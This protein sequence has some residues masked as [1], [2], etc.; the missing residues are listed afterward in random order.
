MNIISAENY[1]MRKDLSLKILTVICALGFF[2]FGFLMKVM[3]DMSGDMIAAEADIVAS[4]FPV[5]LSGKNSIF[6][7]PQFYNIITICCGIFAGTYIVGEFDK[8][9]IRNALT[10]GTSK[11]SYYFAKLYTQVIFCLFLTLV[12]VLAFGA[13]LTLFVGWN[14]PF[15][16]NY[17]LSLLAFTGMMFLQFFSYTALFQMIAFLIRNVGGVI[18]ICVAWVTLESLIVQL[19][20]MTNISFL[21]KIAE[22]LPYSALASLTRFAGNNTLLTADFAKF[23]IPAVIIIIVAIPIGLINFIK[24]D[25]K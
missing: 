20:A 19:L 17:A 7:L 10:T 2:G 6:L 8:G 12:S 11:V 22:C 14:A 18:G 1:K 15:E 5:A 21:N 25:I 13:S 16:G 4:L 9:T 23:A 24:R 3:L